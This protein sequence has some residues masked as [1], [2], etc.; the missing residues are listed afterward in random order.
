MSFLSSAHTPISVHIGAEYPGH[1]PNGQQHVIV[2]HK[3]VGHPLGSG[4][5]PLDAPQPSDDPGGRPIPGG[6]SSLVGQRGLGLRGL[7]LQQEEEKSREEGTSRTQHG[8]PQQYDLCCDAHGSETE[9][10]GEKEETSGREGLTDTL[11]PQRRKRRRQ[12][13]GRKRPRY[14]QA[15]HH[16]INTNAENGR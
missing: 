5:P 4:A 11:S 8:S 10:G 2:S 15:L 7:G 9:E 6:F 12:R 1:Q 3:R 13:R 16:S 14:Q